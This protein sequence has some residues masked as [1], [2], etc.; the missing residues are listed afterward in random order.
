MYLRKP[1]TDYF[2]RWDLDPRAP[3]SPMPS[4]RSAGTQSHG[5]T[6]YRKPLKPAVI[7]LF[8]CGTIC[9]LSSP[10]RGICCNNQVRP[11]TIPLV[12]CT[13]M[14]SDNASP[15][16]AALQARILFHTPLQKQTV[17]RAVSRSWGRALLPAVPGLFIHQGVITLQMLSGIF[18]YTGRISAQEAFLRARAAFCYR[19]YRF[20]FIFCHHLP[21]IPSVLSLTFPNINKLYAGIRIHI[22][23]NKFIR[24]IG[25]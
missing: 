18:L 12:C 25:L 2:D 6:G 23:G 4:C 20:Q 19:C 16:R 22:P 21:H 1:S 8:R 3:V 7:L 15:L 10:H 24:Y 9:Q 11:N 17:S 13:N 5:S 14:V